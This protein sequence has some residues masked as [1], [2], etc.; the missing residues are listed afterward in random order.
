MI[1]KNIFANN[2]FFTLCITLKWSQKNRKRIKMGK[3]QKKYEMVT[4]GFEPKPISYEAI[5]WAS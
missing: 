5:V 4:A 2:R 1:K 3:C